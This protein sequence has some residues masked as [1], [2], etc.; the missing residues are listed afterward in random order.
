MIQ[1]PGPAPP[2]ST[3]CMHLNRGE[4]CQRWRSTQALIVGQLQSGQARMG[5]VRLSV[6]WL[7]HWSDAMLSNLTTTYQIASD[8]DDF[9]YSNCLPNPA[10]HK[11]RCAPSPA[12]TFL[13]FHLLRLAACDSD[14]RAR[15]F[16]CRSYS[17]RHPG[18]RAS[19]MVSLPSQLRSHR[20][21]AK[22]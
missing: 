21:L 18:S 7:A 12:S 3:S 14:D 11:E 1:S 19:T 2:L 20:R 5:L 16:V 9:G 17:L 22:S 8:I 4:Y 10:H 13:R 15:L 6:I